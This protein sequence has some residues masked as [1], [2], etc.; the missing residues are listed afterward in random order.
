[1]R[2]GVE[3][4]ER[5]SIGGKP[6]RVRQLAEVGEDLELRFAFRVNTIAHRLRF[7]HLVLA[8]AGIEREVRFAEHLLRGDVEP[9]GN[10]AAAVVVGKV[11]QRS[12]P[13][14]VADVR[15]EA[16]AERVP[17][18]RAR[19]VERKIGELI[20]AREPAFQRLR[21]DRH[22]LR[23][24]AHPAAGGDVA[25]RE[26][27]EALDEPGGLRAVRDPELTE[28]GVEGGGDARDGFEVEDVRVLVVEKLRHPVVEIADRGARIGRRR[29]SMHQRVEDWRRAAVGEVGVVGEND[30]RPAVGDVIEERR[31]PRM[32]RF[33]HPG[34]LG[35]EAVLAL[36][37]VDL[38]MRRVDRLPVEARVGGARGPGAEQREGD[39]DAPHAQEA[40]R[41]WGFLPEMRESH[42]SSRRAM[43]WG[44]SMGATCVPP[45]T[46]SISEPEMRRCISSERRYGVKVSSVPAT[47]SVG[48]FTCSRWPSAECSLACLSMPR[49]SAGSIPERWVK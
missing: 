9:E 40:A 4:V 37:E 14:L 18:G 28:D 17:A 3:E 19:P 44:C 41:S 13:V 38:E 24:G 21:A 20:D 6:G 26:G 43:S 1:M 27:G 11:A 25:L 22:L 23:R 12:H 16:A 42:F 32:G 36:V 7:L 39:G 2:A 30:L 45:G 49:K 35:R 15:E 46:E 8:E 33:R 48:T 31:E 5:L 10:G 34:E 29:E 47:M